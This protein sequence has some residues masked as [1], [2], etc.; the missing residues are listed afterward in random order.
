MAIAILVS[1]VLSNGVADRLVTKPPGRKSRVDTILVR[2]DQ[3]ALLDDPSNNRLDR[4]LLYVLEH[5]DED[6]TGALQDAEN[7]RLFLRQS[8]PA[9]RP[10]QAP[11]SGFAAFF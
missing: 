10:F 1:G 5:L 6:V 4:S 9:R 11:P 7:R 3:A 8:A 2:I